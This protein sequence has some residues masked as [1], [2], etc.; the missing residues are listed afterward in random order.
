MNHKL[1]SRLRAGIECAPW[2]IEEVKKLEA[3]IQAQ[4]VPA[5]H[6]VVPVEPTPEMLEAGLKRRAMVKW[7]DGSSPLRAR[8][9]NLRPSLEVAALQWEAMLAAAPKIATEQAEPIARADWTTPTTHL[10][11]FGDAMQ[12][13]CGGVRPSDTLLADWM[14]DDSHGWLQEFAIEHGP[15]WSQGI[16]LIDAAQLMADQPTEGVDHERIDKDATQPEQAEQAGEVR[17]DAERWSAYY[18]GDE[19]VSLC[20]SEGEAIGEME[21]SI[22]QDTDPGHEIEFC[23]APMVSAKQALRK[24]SALW[25]GEDIFEHINE[26]IS[27]DIGAEEEPLDLSKD[28][29]EKLGQQVIEFFCQNAKNQWWTVDSER[30]QK[31]TYVAGSNDAAIAAAPAAQANPLIVDGRSCPTCRDS[32]SWGIADKSSCLGCSPTPDGKGTRYSPLNQAAAPAGEKP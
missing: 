10:Q 25:T 1:S 5:G 9:E 21:C 7:K 22:D 26:L 24:R 30:E 8:T 2:V 13:L 20:D 23:V 29:K 4:Q 28:D 3:A 11:R 32:D 17:E 6:V 14:A 12:L 16:G 31:R 19:R 27:D 15:A 18:E